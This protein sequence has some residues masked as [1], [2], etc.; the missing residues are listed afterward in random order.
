MNNSVGKQ[1]WNLPGLLIPS[2]GL[3]LFF[4]DHR[5]INFCF[6]IFKDI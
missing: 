2:S 1:D 3:F 5:I 4:K 6:F